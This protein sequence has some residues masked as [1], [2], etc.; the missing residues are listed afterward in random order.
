[1]ASSCK[2]ELLGESRKQSVSKP[3]VMKKV[4]SEKVVS[5][6]VV[7][8]KIVS[9]KKVVPHVNL[10]ISPSADIQYYFTDVSFY[11]NNCDGQL[12]PLVEKRRAKS[13][14]IVNQVNRFSDNIVR[15]I[16]LLTLLSNEKRWK[17]NHKRLMWKSF[18]LISFEK[19]HVVLDRG[20]CV[21]MD[22]NEKWVLVEAEGIVYQ[23]FIKR[24]ICD[25]AGV[26]NNKPANFVNIDDNI[27][28]LH[29]IKHR[30]YKENGQ[31]WF[32]NNCR[33]RNCDLVRVSR[34]H[35]K[36][37]SAGGL[38]LHSK[39]RNKYHSLKVDL[40]DTDRWYS[41]EYPFELGWELID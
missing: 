3:V 19:N 28:D 4:I 33:C 1:M 13:P 8:E 31:Y 11:H 26:I 2:W 10:F 17:K 14:Y 15:Y 35:S 7:S 20:T 41:F 16:Y 38:E 40:V 32:L 6:K 21:N 30:K 34:L 25:T 37:K 12:F 18:Q 39:I 9:E 29:D 36:C 5:E 27:A 23:N 22:H 24:I